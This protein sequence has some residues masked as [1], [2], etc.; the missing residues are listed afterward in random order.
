LL[1]YASRRLDLRRMRH[2]QH[3]R[4][5][6]IA[7][8]V[9]HRLGVLEAAYACKDAV[10]AYCQTAN[11]GCA[12][13][14]R[15]A[16]NQNEGHESPLFLEGLKGCGRSVRYRNEPVPFAVNGLRNE[17]PSKGQSWSAASTFLRPFAW[18]DGFIMEALSYQPPSRLHLRMKGPRMGPFRT[19]GGFGC[20]RRE[21]WNGISGTDGLSW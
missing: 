2:I 3:N 6:P 12:D 10:T 20:R 14:F 5:D 15:C 16:G 18:H 1:Y 4:N 9:Y 19:S 13:P 8:G 7:V 11:A 17:L 21:R